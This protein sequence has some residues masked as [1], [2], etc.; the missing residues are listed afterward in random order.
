MK[1][2]FLILLVL[3]AF[4][5]VAQS[6]EMRFDGTVTNIDAA[7]KETGVNVSLVQGG[8]TVISTTT[9][10]NGKYSLKGMVNY[11]QPFEI[12]FS[13]GG[14]VNKK[15]SFNLTG[16]NE[17]DTP[18]GD[19]RPVQSL[20][21]EI[22]GN[23]PNADFSFLDSQPVAQFFWD[24]TA[25]TVDFNKSQAA[26]MRTKIDK[27]LQDAEN[28]A[29][30]N[31]AKYNQAI[32]AADKA[33]A[34][35]EYEGA[36]SK[37]EE[38]LSY[39]PKEKYP[40][41]K[42]L[43]LDALI[44]K[45]KE[46]QLA[47]QQQNA[48]YY[49]LIQAADN[50]RNAKEYEKAKAKYNEA[51]AKKD[52]QY[53]K[54]EIKKIDGILKEKENQAA[55]DAAIELG[56]MML[57][58]KS[59]KAA[60]D[61]YT[62]ATKLKPS[63]Q[64]PKDKLAELEAKIKAQEDIENNKKK[65]EAAVAEGDKLFTEESWEASK[66]KYQEALTYESA[67]TYPSGR[68][69]MIDEK[70]AALKAEKEK[71]EQIAKLLQEGAAAEAAKKYEDALA[72]YKS[73]LT[74][75]AANAVA[76]QKIPQLEQ[77][78]ADAAKN[79]E[80]EA[81]FE[82][83]VDKGD[84]AATAKKLEDAIVNY[85]SALQLKQDVAVQTKLT[86]VKKQ[87]DELKNAEE[88]KAQYDKL[89]T[90]G[91]S[92]FDAKDYTTALQKYEGAKALKP[93]ETAPQL[94][95]DEINALI[96]KQ[97]ADKAKSE[98]IAALIQEGETLFGGEQWEASKAKFNDVLKLEATNAVAK[99]K[100]KQIDAKLLELQNQ[101]ANEAKFNEWV[102]KGD[103]EV[104][105]EK[106]QAAIVNYKEA[107]KMKQDAAVQ[108]KVD[109]AQAKLDALAADKAKEEQYQAA[110]KTADKQFSEKKYE[111]AKASY[112]SALT[113]KPSESYPT[114]KITAINQ[115]L[116]DMASTAEKEN[117]IKQLLAEGQTLLTAKDYVPAKS[118]YEQVLSLAPDN[119]TAQTKL[120]EINAAMAALMDQQA[121][122][123][124]FNQLK[125]EGM[126][127]AAQSQWNPAKLKL[128]E[129]LQIKT[130]AEVK[131]KIDEIDALLLAAKNK[132]ATIQTLLTDGEK[133]Y[134]DKKF[135]NARAKYEQV[136]VLDGS[137]AVATEKLRQ[138]DSELAKLMGAQQQEAEF[139]RLKQ[140]G[141]TAATAKNWALAKS[142]LQQALAI[143]DDEAIRKKLTEIEAAQLAE[144]QSNELNEK[145]E[146]AMAAAQSSEAKQN[147]S[148]AINRYKEAS[149]LK[150][151]EAL[152][153]TK[154]T[155]LTEL[156]SKQSASAELDKKYNALIDKG[157]ALVNGQDYI[158]A[159]AAYNEAL[160]LKPTEQLPVEKAKRAQ[161]LAD[162]QNKSEEDTQYEK[163]LATISTK[164]K[165]E[166]YVKAREYI[167]RALKLR[168]EDGRPK[169]L[170]SE[171]ELI[172]RQNAQFA[173][174][175]KDG[176]KEANAKNIEK[177]IG[178]YE[179]AKAVKPANPEPQAR[180]D[181]LR[182]EL[183][184]SNED[185]EKNALFKQY[186]DAGVAN[187]SSGQLQLALSDYNNALNVK[188]D[189]AATKAK[190]AEV[191]KALD[192]MANDK[193]NQLA[194][195]QELSA[196]IQ[197]ADSHF[198]SK[199]YQKSV[200]IYRKALAIEPGSRYVQ[201]RINE[202]EKL[203]R[204]E[205]LASLQQEYQKIL[206][207]ADNNFNTGNYSKAIE[208]YKRALSLKPSDAYP[209]KKLAE[210]DAI[211]NPVS[212]T[213]PA[214]EP[215]GEVYDNSIMDGGTALAI[216][217]EQR[218][219]LRIT[220]M[221][222]RLDGIGDSE[223][224]MTSQKTDD[225]RN[226]SNEIYRI[227]RSVSDDATNR[228]LN[229]QEVVEVLRAAEIEQATVNAMEAG[230]ERAENLQSRSYIETVQVENA[231]DYGV[232]ESVYTE[233]HG[234]VVRIQTDAQ[235]TYSYKSD[236]F[237]AE[238][239]ETG[240]AL[241]AA[242]MDFNTD[243]LENNEKRINEALRVDEVRTDAQNILTDK[244]YVAY[245]GTLVT[246]EVVEGVYISVNEE[247]AEKSTWAGANAE[248]VKVIEGAVIEQAS[249]NATDN[250]LHAQATDKEIRALQLKVEADNTNRDLNRLETVEVMKSDANRFAEEARNQSSQEGGKYLDNKAAIEGQK[251]INSEIDEKADLRN[252]ENTATVERLQKQ[253]SIQV[254]GYNYSDEQERQSAQMGVDK[255]K[256]QTEQR[257]SEEA[258]KV[259]DN[260]TK[261]ND[262]NKSIT[263]G[264]TST[265]NEKTQSIYASKQAIDKVES[266]G[267]ERAVITNNLGEEYPEGVSQEVFQRKD[268]NGILS[269]IITRRIVVQEGHGD[270]YV[271]TQTLNATTY[272][273]NGNPITEYVWQKETQAA[274]LERHY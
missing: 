161:E 159:I 22:F 3:C 140:E 187:Q 102:T 211:Q 41:D 197:E 178:L 137:N 139:N 77:L 40:S 238:N 141:F 120:T 105:G 49:N 63:E 85:E 190:I 180:I 265:A 228:D 127:L 88:L 148:D 104:A 241:E 18:A 135:E 83:F 147:Y 61:K 218:E 90:E 151:T 39:K 220:K 51:L 224:E 166:D 30:E 65:Y 154:I 128:Q 55:Y 189:D 250:Q 248:H 165:E 246:K 146:T 72:K 106:W 99:E 95:I 183:A 143:K 93:A 15:V 86:E 202:A 98:Q 193:Q 48:E 119:A 233:N 203:S 17:E 67:A 254:E 50:F 208:Y 94:K 42:I 199:N 109:A 230:Y 221:K 205:T 110:I 130:D 121:K 64:Y 70:L 82:Q 116:A 195:Q 204:Q 6:L 9:A 28:K 214:L 66:A 259:I 260:G 107:L 236:N 253:A 150:P 263:V 229:R 225:H 38:A 114:E 27:L 133:L 213:G 134:N 123:E 91:K 162:A 237:Y 209:K 226:N 266:K 75:D 168:P 157:D 223:A 261:I 262:V 164:I 13:K 43:E 217:Q 97:N 122:D 2:F 108:Q 60:R 163:I 54:D 78:I 20:D 89:M 222:N 172:E 29:A 268:E 231:I 53:P 136:L 255:V 21:M 132:E 264:N 207:A 240:Q 69:K 196:L 200:E 234:K 31:E 117:Q 131:A 73:V 92:A 125:Q 201:Q 96:E 87:L 33:Y 74:L 239:I 45:Q 84:A 81:K 251:T 206:L 103:A 19:F 175:M 194:R 113:I 219:S 144:L 80:M 58:Q 14:F 167:D 257:S 26:Q 242:N 149:A 52:E 252:A 181:A 235:D 5:G 245:D 124:Q 76:T 118:K 256:I 271:K 182:Q 179:Q 47:D 62:E 272:S 185:A 138:I 171:I 115:L 267:V 11:N 212:E 8:S 32:A 100:I 169:A 174:L 1:H 44:Q 177:A 10:S 273:K 210:I 56:D 176:E 101:A 16:L 4:D 12:V 34:A 142:S 24:K 249:K 192:K 270:V 79:A 71:Q 23:R 243:Y 68:I 129:A 232:R 173:A 155:E 188:P 25:F 170:L 156:L 247:N 269:A 126:G 216:A 184:S 57:K 186:F 191:Q 111:L 198:D 35:K 227:Y 145:Y 152:P 153:K 215:L 158:G 7:K 59:Y 160:A 46:A 112:E 244:G 36:L 274:H 37:Y 258:V